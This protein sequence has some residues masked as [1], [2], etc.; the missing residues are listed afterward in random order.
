[1]SV[2]MVFCG[3]HLSLAFQFVFALAPPSKG[4]ANKV[5]GKPK[6]SLCLVAPPRAALRDT[7]QIVVFI[8]GPLLE[9]LSAVSKS[10]LR[11]WLQ[12]RPFERRPKTGKIERQKATTNQK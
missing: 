10:N 1:M 7:V 11:E 3:P 6:F 4:A 8:G 12:N 5:E 9:T 2:L